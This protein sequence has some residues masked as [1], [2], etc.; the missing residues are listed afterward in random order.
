M[1]HTVTR[2]RPWNE[3]EQRDR[4]LNQLG[5]ARIIVC[6]ACDAGLLKLVRSIDH[7]HL[8]QLQILPLFQGRGIGTQIISALQA[9]CGSEGIPIILNVYSS[10][11]RAIQLYCG[12]GSRSPIA[13]C[14]PIK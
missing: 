13:V 9:E 12:A 2:H 10:N 5:H 6:D 1:R 7:A 11:N 3:K 4:A 8:S 14:I